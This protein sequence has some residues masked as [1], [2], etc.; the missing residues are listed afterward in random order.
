MTSFIII[1][2]LLRHTHTQNHVSVAE[3]ERRS[4]RTGSR[5]NSS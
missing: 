5:E 2:W 3:L 4:P 1:Y